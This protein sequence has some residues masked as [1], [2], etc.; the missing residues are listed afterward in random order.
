M[1][2]L[3]WTGAVVLLVISSLLV[4]ASVTARFARS[5]LLNTDRYVET[6]AP[7]ASDPG[8]QQAITT[9]VTDAVMASADLPA[10]IQQLAEATGIKAAPQAATLAAPAITN[11][12]QGQVKRIVGDLVSSP[13]FA[14]LWTEV[15]RSAHTQIDKLLTGE[16]GT[17]VSTQDTDIVINLGPVVAAARDNLVAR[18]WGFLSKVPDVSIPYTVATI[19]D[20]PQIQRYVK[21]LDKAG[22]WLPILALVLLGLGVWCAPNHR[23][24]LLVGLV[25]SAVLLLITLAAYAIF[26]NR[27]AD[28]L[29]A[30]G[31]NAD[32]ALTVWD[33]L[34][35]YFVIALAT[36]TVA[37][38]LAAIWVYLAGPG[39]GAR[40][41]RRGVN[42]A[43]DPVGRA[44]GPQ[45][46]VRRFIHRWQPW[47]AVILAA[48]AM[49]WLLASPTVATAFL[50]VAV[51]ALLTAV[52]T[53]LRRLPA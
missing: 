31:F 52:I 11:W 37:A 45:P 28:K 36:T 4:V 35:R 27:Y 29:T 22:T 7:L 47:I 48:G 21:L 46:G 53:L 44:I 19:D 9:R 30:K 51:V 43:I 38:A 42:T 10:L 20:L 2:T 49:W 24:A 25:I 40:L 23:R 39:R 16:D 15:N 1:R 18:G 41:F 13:Q 34:L 17:V 14:T 26:R 12:I 33:Q 50:I 5:E 3:R 8:V 32:V 6:V